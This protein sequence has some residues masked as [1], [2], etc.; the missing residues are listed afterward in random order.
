MSLIELWKSGKDQITGKR[1][2][3][4]I[5]FAGDG[6]LA[7]GNSTSTEFREFLSVVPTALL[8]NFSN[9]CLEGSFQDSGFVLQDIVNEIGRRLDFTVQDGLYRGRRGVVG[10]D[11]LWTTNEGDTVLVEIKTTETYQ[12]NLDTIADYRKRLIAEREL[13]GEKSSILL[14]VGRLDTGGLEAQIR[15]SRHAWDI[16]LISVEALSNL[17][18]IKQELDD[19]LVFYKIQQILKPKEYTKLDDIID[20]VFSTKEDLKALDNHEEAEEESQG[21][22]AIEREQYVSFHE[23]C[24]KKVSDF[25][26]LE[27]L[28]ESRVTFAT[29]DKTVAVICSVSKEYARSKGPH[30]WFAF[31]PHQQERLQKAEKGYLALGCGSSAQTVLI[32]IERLNTFIDAL[33]QTNRNGRSYWHLKISKENKKIYI[34]TK[35]GRDEITISE[36]LIPA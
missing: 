25:L 18:N 8:V 9:Q 30:Y 5:A 17:L 10:F 33:H 32:P 6:K 19:P 28:Q 35:S 14:V 31:H 7:D 22:E 36:Y 23:E 15:G 29:P 27:L 12:I 26:G 21:E 24:I 4:I 2:Q 16:R 13:D 34:N 1:L 11:G 20:L 3:Q